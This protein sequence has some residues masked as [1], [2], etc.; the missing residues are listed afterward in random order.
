MDCFVKE[1]FLATAL[2]KAPNIVSPLLEGEQN[3][4]KRLE[5]E[6]PQKRIY[7]EVKGVVPG[8]KRKTTLIEKQEGRN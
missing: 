5:K 7:D 1:G 8:V 6:K 4:E 2:I 3:L